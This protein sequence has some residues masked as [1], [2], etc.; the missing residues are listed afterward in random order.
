MAGAT[1]V[2]QAFYRSW[3][4]DLADLRRG[5]V[6]PQLQVEHLGVTLAEGCRHL[7]HEGGHVAV[8]HRDLGVVGAGQ[9][10]LQVEP[11]RGRHG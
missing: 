11:G 5:E 6:E 10:R 8:G 3:A 2:P 4:D 1:A 7:V 9:A